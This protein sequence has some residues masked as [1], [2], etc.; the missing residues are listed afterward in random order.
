MTN[1]KDFSVKVLKGMN[2]KMN[3]FMDSVYITDLADNTPFK[4]L[5]QTKEDEISENKDRKLNNIVLN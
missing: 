3:Y 2:H 5:P 1:D 4:L